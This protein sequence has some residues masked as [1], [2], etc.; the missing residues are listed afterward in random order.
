MCQLGVAKTR[1]GPGP[2]MT[3]ITQHAM[4]QMPPRER[5]EYIPENSILGHI[6]IPSNIQANRPRLCHACW[7]SLGSKTSSPC[8]GHCK[9]KHPVSPGNV[10]SGYGGLLVPLAQRKEM[11]TWV[12][13]VPASFDV[14]SPSSVNVNGSNLDEKCVCRWISPENVS[15]PCNRTFRH[16]RAPP[17]RLESH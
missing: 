8:K 11:S 17:P 13:F 4:L 2:E 12:I 6:F 5:D 16:H 14:M 1:A 9:V 10:W 7:D 3:L 15:P